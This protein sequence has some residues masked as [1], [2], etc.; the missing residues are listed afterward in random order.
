MVHHLDWQPFFELQNYVRKL[1]AI[2]GCLGKHCVLTSKLPQL[3]PAS[4]LLMQW[5]QKTGGNS[6]HAVQSKPVQKSGRYGRA[7]SWERNGMQQGPSFT[8]SKEDDETQ[9][10]WRGSNSRV[11]LV[12]IGQGGK[13][14]TVKIRRAGQDWRELEECGCINMDRGIHKNKAEMKRWCLFQEQRGWLT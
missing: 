3:I 13:R 9:D 2:V 10:D 6:H 5:N 11:I 4:Q 7:V 14:L 1:Y 8:V 12:Y